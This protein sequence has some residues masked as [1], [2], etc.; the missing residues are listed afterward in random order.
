MTR[1]PT[2]GLQARYRDRLTP[3][4]VGQRVSVRH[5]GDATAEDPRPSDVVGRLLADDGDALVL[6]DRHEQLH[7]VGRDTVLSAKVVPPHPRRDPE[8]W[9][10]TEDAPLR[11]E[12]AR[13]LLLD[14]QGRALLIAHKP[15]V[16]QQIWTAPGGGVR[17]GEDHVSAARREL[18]EELGLDLPIGPWVWSRE[19][20]FPF[21]GVW[22]EQRERWYLA[23]TEVWDPA[24][25]PLDDH[26]ID[27]AR[28]FTVDE[29][30]DDDLDVAPTAFADHLTALLRDG[31]TDTPIDV[32]R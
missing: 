10:G 7:V 23:D 3:D 8:P 4:D 22:L 9:V 21:R 28:W 20:R 11:R 31:P 15:E 26:G 25:A 27:E 29:L 2:P 16:D 17:P 6:V 18:A 14:P 12:A 30:R 13:I 1:R 24:A 5:R 19:V 32:G